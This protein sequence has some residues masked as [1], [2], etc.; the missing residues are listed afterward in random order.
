M[1][2]AVLLLANVN[3]FHT[4]SDFLPGIRRFSISLYQ[5]SRI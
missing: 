5:K 2:E 4:L 1:A 3:Y